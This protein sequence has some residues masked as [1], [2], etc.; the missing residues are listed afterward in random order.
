MSVDYISEKLA[1]AEYGLATGLGSIQDRLSGAGQYLR[2]IT[3]AERDAAPTYR[4]FRER[5]KTVVRQLTEPKNPSD[6][7][8]K[9][10]GAIEAACQQLDDM[11]AVA[12]AKEICELKGLAADLYEQELQARQKP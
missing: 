5:F 11:E 10:D 1:E 2:R 12:V 3:P 6:P 7:R 4:D 9:T 8:V